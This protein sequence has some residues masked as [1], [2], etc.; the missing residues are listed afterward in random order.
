MT[1]F[2]HRP[3]YRDL[4]AIVVLYIA[5]V[6]MFRLAFAGFGLEQEIALFLVNAMGG[7]LIMGV[8]GPAVYMV[9]VRGENLDS[10]PFFTPIGSF[11]KNI[12]AGNIAL[13]W[14]SIIGFGVVDSGH[15]SGAAH[16]P[17]GGGQKPGALAQPGSSWVSPCA[18]GA[19]FWRQSRTW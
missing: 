13:P 16:C 14:E 10:W 11:F 18:T 3:D 12:Q 15:G 7:M 6:G 2:Q 5:A 19:A 1:W 4:M 9:L 8:A 17:P